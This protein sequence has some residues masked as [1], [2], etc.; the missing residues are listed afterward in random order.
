MN[1]QQ[2]FSDKVAMLFEK[3]DRENAGYIT[4]WELKTT[5]KLT[6]N[7]VERIE[8]YILYYATH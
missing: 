7:H 6:K 5:I 1:G 3:R 4:D 8:S 2:I